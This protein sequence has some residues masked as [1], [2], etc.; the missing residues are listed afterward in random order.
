MTHLYTY[1]THSRTSTMVMITARI[2][3][4]YLHMI[5]VR[6]CKTFNGINWHYFTFQSLLFT[7]TLI[8][9]RL[10]D[11]PWESHHIIVSSREWDGC[12]NMLLGSKRSCLGVICPHIWLIG[13]DEVVWP[14]PEPVQSTLNTLKITFNITQSCTFKD[15]WQIIFKGEKT[16]CILHIPWMIWIHT[17]LMI[18]VSSPC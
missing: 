8:C 9:Y 5:W 7:T 11:W 15:K 1:G 14:C 17:R 18:S 10:S 3:E 2:K 16:F 6:V 4:H 12:R 13:V